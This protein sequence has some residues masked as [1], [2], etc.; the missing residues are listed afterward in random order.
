MN[1]NIIL[2][3]QYYKINI[4]NMIQTYGMV[5]LIWTHNTFSSRYI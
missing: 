3:I 2:S 5:K 4:N 1:H